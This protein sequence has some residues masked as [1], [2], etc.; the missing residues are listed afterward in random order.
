MRNLDRLALALDVVDRFENPRDD[1]R[2]ATWDE[3]SLYLGADTLDP[4][5]EHMSPA[6]KTR[7]LE[8]AREEIWFFESS[9]SEGMVDPFGATRRRVV[10]E[11]VH[12]QP[13]PWQ[14]LAPLPRGR[15]SME[16]GFFEMLQKILPHL[17]TRSVEDVLDELQPIWRTVFI[18]ALG[19]AVATHLATLE[20]A[21][22]AR[23][24]DVTPWKKIVGWWACRSTEPRLCVGH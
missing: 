21:C 3:L 19:Q 4:V 6:L 13:Y 14:P 16:L 20:A 12:R 22:A 23:G 5:Y 15:A 24:E 10:G 2:R 18:P 7:F 8:F 11:W 17:V 1:A 9:I